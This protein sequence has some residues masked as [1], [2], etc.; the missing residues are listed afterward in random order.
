MT[1]ADW[2]ELLAGS[3]VCLIVLAVWLLLINH[4][5]VLG[6]RDLE[7]RLEADIARNEAVE[8][9]QAGGWDARVVKS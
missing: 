2:H 7:A 4:L 5:H 8:T 9:L 6:L 1:L 3:A